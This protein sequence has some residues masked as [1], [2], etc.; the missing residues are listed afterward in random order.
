MD[1]KII[2]KIQKLLALSGSS[3]K[4]EAESA[5]EKAQELMLKHNIDMRSVKQHDS[6]YINELSETFKREHPSMKYINS[7]VEKYFFVKIVKSSRREGKFFNYIGEK[8]NVQTAI[9]T[10]NFL[11]V[12]FDRFWKEYKQ[13][14]DATRGSK[15]SFVLGLYNGFCEKMDQQRQE[16]EQKFD[17]ILV[18]DPKATDKM[19][20]LFPRLSRRSAPRINRLDGSAMNAGHIAGK[21][22][23][24]SAGFLR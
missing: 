4:N 13:E 20:E 9:H 1:N 12:T 24:L 19:N 5:M 3:N 6:E 22:I 2:E 8:T 18:E 11:K 16:A 17:M 15:Q 14:T 21:K 10:V 7:I 23:T